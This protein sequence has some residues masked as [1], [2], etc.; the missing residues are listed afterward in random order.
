MQCRNHRPG[1]HVHVICTQLPISRKLEFRSLGG[2][3][4]T[5]IVNKSCYNQIRLIIGRLPVS[6]LDTTCSQVRCFHITEF[7]L[8]C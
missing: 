3:A 5:E 2:M 1:P 6:Y 4:G 7:L 8:S